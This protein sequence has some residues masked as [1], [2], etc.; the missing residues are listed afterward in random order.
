MYS[1][2]SKTLLYKSKKCISYLYKAFLESIDVDHVKDEVDGGVD[3]KHEMSNIDQIFNMYVGWTSSSVWSR[4]PNGT[5]EL[6]DIGNNGKTLTKYK[7]RNHSFQ[8]S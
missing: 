1:S 5:N 6:I 7:H 3:G 2:Y 8:D 4:H